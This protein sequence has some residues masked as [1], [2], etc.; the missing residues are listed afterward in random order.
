MKNYTYVIVGGGM[1][2]DSAIKGIREVDEK[3]SIALIGAENYPPYNRPRLTKGLWT[4]KKKLEEIWRQ[5]ARHRA[6]L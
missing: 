1:A 3:G 6:D 2:A 4:G 5:T